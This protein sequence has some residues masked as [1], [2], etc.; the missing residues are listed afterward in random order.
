[1]E[2]VTLQQVELEQL[3][4]THD[5]LNKIIGELGEIEIQRH[6][7]T[8]AKNQILGDLA[9]LKQQQETLGKELNIKYGKGT[10]NLESGEFIKSA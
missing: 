1:M 8:L 4:K 5:D 10:I 7:L 9:K 3:R 2:K 6:D